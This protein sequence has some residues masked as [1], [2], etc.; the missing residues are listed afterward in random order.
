MCAKSGYARGQR[1]DF[2]QCL[3]LGFWNKLH[4]C[5]W[6]IMIKNVWCIEGVFT[7]AEPVITRSRMFPMLSVGKSTCCPRLKY[8]SSWRNVNIKNSKLMLMLERVE[9]KV[10]SR[11]YISGLRSINLA[12]KKLITFFAISASPRSGRGNQQQPPWPELQVY[13]RQE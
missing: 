2:C 3:F 7:G 6:C 5:P 11:L 1:P 13:W 4:P 10:E 12:T 9:K 8:C